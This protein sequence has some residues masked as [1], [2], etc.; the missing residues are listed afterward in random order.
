MIVRRFSIGRSF[1]GIIY[2]QS[3]FCRTQKKIAVRFQDTPHFNQDAFLR[4]VI[5]IDQH[6]ADEYNIHLGNHRPGHRKI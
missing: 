4:F 5:E 6:I 3:R 1:I 2:I